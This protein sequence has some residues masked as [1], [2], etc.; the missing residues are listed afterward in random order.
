[1]GINDSYNRK[2]CWKMPDPSLIS[3]NIYPMTYQLI[4]VLG[5]SYS[6]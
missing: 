4:G 3:G 1:M 6:G 2:L 5:N